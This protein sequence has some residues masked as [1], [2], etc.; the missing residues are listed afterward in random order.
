M[1]GSIDLVVRDRI[2]T[3][4]ISNAERLNTLGNVLICDL[5]AALEAVHHDPDAWVVILR[6]EGERAFCA[7]RDLRE[8][9][10]SDSASSMA[11]SQ[12]MRGLERNLFEVVV[13]CFK[14]VIA[15][16]FGHTLGGRCRACDRF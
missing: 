7:G 11:D 4:T 9:R 13:E 1:H 16:I 12:P 2:A 14:P 15:A 6:A 3:V 5:I 8:V 10:M